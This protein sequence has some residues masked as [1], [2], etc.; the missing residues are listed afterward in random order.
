MTIYHSPGTNMF[1]LFNPPFDSERN[2]IVLPM[3]D[4]LTKQTLH[5]VD[6]VR[7]YYQENI[8]TVKT[9]DRLVKLLVEMQTW[10]D[11]APETLVKVVRNNTPR[12]CNAYNIV[13]PV[14]QGKITN[15]G[16]MY[17]RNNPELF[18]SVEYPFDVKKCVT[19][20]QNLKPLRVVSH[21]FTDFSYNIANGNYLSS[22]SGICIFTIDLA[23]LALQYQ[24]WYHKERYVE[25]RKYHHPTTYFVV[26]YLLTG[27]LSTH[28]DNVLFNRF[29]NRLQGEPCAQGR[30]NPGILLVDYGARYDDLFDTLI[31]KFRRQPTVWTQRLNSLPSLEYSTF[32]RSVSYPDVAAT[33]NIKWAMVLSK[34]KIVEALLLTDQFDGNESFNNFERETIARELRVLRNDRSLVVFLPQKVLDRIE[35]VYSIVNKQSA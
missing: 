6:K 12:L 8:T 11:F 15:Q 21:D 20:Y 28:M 31:E 30:P 33:R 23:L 3:F 19:Y 25:A 5:E 29:L 4:Y 1:S 22:E 18:I 34:L 2:K 26:K 16:E 10:M 32:F 9:S 24:Q 14:S 13:S 35:R 17:N 7:T 27:M